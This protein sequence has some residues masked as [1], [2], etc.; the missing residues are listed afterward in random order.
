MSHVTATPQMLAAAAGDLASVASTINAA[1]ANAAAGTSGL[2]APGADSVSAFV[3]ALFSA[4]AQAYQTAGAQAASY[5][6]QFVQALR[7]SAGSDANTEAANAS[8]LQKV[9]GMVNAASQSSA[10]HLIEKGA[11]GA[12]STAQH[13]GVGGPPPRSAPPS[14]APSHP[15][16]RGRRRPPRARPTPPRGAARTRPHP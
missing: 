3:V 2:N 12:L 16:R 7:E 6:N 11:N 5:H 10:G 4:H 14:R 8:P 15:A 9:S 1:N 13:G